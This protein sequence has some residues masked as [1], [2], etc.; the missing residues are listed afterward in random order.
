MNFDQKLSIVLD[1]AQRSNDLSNDF[2]VNSGVRQSR[3]GESDFKR[4]PGRQ[5]RQ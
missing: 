4:R 2:E 1:S 5:P 3:Q